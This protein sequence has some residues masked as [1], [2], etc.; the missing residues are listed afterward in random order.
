[1]STTSSQSYLNIDITSLMQDI[2]ANPTTSYGIGMRQVVEQTYRSMKFGSS[3]N[4]DSAL[5]PK[6][7]ICY[8]MPAAGIHEHENNSALAIYP[9]PANDFLTIKTENSKMQ[10]NEIRVFD[11]QGKMVM[12]QIVNAGEASVV[13]DISSLAN[14]IYFVQGIAEN[15]VMNKKVL[16]TH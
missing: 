2:W 11:A 8:S 1:V 12:N 6:L 3:D 15:E 13:L 14:G 10:L 7:Y 9:N 5:W 4:P 16:V